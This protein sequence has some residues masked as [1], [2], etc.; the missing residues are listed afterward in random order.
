VAHVS[1]SI[2]RPSIALTTA[3]PLETAAVRALLDNP[4]THTETDLRGARQYI[5]GTMP[6]NQGETHSVVLGMVGVGNNIAAAA[7]TQLLEDFPTVETVIVVGIAGGVP[8]PSNVQEHVRL[9]DIVVSNERGVVQY[10]FVKDEP[11]RQI[12]RHPPR[13]PSAPFVRAVR[14]LEAEALAGHSPWNDNINL[15]LTKL[16]WTRPLAQSDILL[17]TD[18][19]YLALLHPDDP[20]RVDGAPRVFVGPIA[21][22]NTLLKNP[23]RRDKLRDNF[24]VKAVEMEGSGTADAAWIATIG[25][26]IVRGICDYCSRR[27]GICSGSPSDH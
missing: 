16:G 19:P 2:Y 17:S 1:G 20:D 27:R 22:S 25:H 9:G 3:L 24:G 11:K 21:S 6:A 15:G 5:L 14:M 7:T 23:K 8:N 13:P 26:L 10:D 12:S 4:I 18:T